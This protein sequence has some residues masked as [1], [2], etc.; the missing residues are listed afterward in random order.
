MLKLRY[1]LIAIAMPCSILL[2]GINS[3]DALEITAMYEIGTGDDW[4]DGGWHT[5]RVEVDGRKQLL[6][7]VVCKR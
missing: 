5:G 2:F 1:I 6:C 7:R 4:G 3:S